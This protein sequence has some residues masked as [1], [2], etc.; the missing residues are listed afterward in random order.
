[1]L[2][3]ELKQ[4][5]KTGVFVAQSLPIA[6]HEENKQEILSFYCLSN[7]FSTLFLAIMAIQTLTEKSEFDTF[8]SQPG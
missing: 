2:A 1:M 4:Q 7:S 3:D 6:F 5:I 8:V